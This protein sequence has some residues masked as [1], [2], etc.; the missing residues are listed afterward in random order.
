MFGNAPYSARLGPEVTRK[1]DTN[2]RAKFADKSNFTV[3]LLRGYL[4]E[5]G[6]V[7]KVC[8]YLQLMQVTVAPLTSIELRPLTL[9]EDLAHILNWIQRSFTWPKPLGSVAVHHLTSA[10]FHHRDSC[11]LNVGELFSCT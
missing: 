9:A 3:L 1:S 2:R 8:L 10:M 6:G 5:G 7:Q 11:I 4:K